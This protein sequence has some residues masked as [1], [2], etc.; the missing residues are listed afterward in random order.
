M[1]NISFQVS[2]TCD[3]FGEFISTIKGI[4]VTNIDPTNIRVGTSWIATGTSETSAISNS[5]SGSTRVDIT[6]QTSYTF[7]NIPDGT[8]FIAISDSN[9]PPNVGVSSGITIA[10]DATPIPTTTPTRTPTSTPTETPISVNCSTSVFDIVLLFDESGSILEQDF[11]KMMQAAASLV[12]KLSP[13][14]GSGF[15]IGLTEF[16]NSSSNILNL[17]SNFTTITNA[18]L[19]NP[20]SF[21]GTNLSLGLDTAYSNVTGI[22]TRN[23]NKKII[24]YTDGNPSNATLAAQSAATI[25][26]SLYN[27][28]YRTEIICV[29]IGSSIDYNFLQN[30]IASSPSLVFSASS[31]NSLSQLNTSIANSI[32]QPLSSPTPT[33]TRTVTQTPTPT[34]TRTA[35]QTPTPTPT[36]TA[37]QTPTPTPTRTPNATTTPTPT[38]NATTTPTATPTKTAP[39]CQLVQVRTNTGT[40]CS[41]TC[42]ILSLESVYARLPLSDGSKIYYAEADPNAALT[43]CQNLGTYWEGAI[44]SIAYDGVC[45]LVDNDGV[46]SNGTPCPTQTQTPTSTQTRTP[47]PTPTETQT[48]CYSFDGKYGA[49]IITNC[50]NLCLTTGYDP[51]YS[52]T[53]IITDGIRIFATFEDCSANNTSFPYPGIVVIDGTCYTVDSGGILSSGTVC[54]TPTPT[55]TPTR[56]ATSTPTRTATSTPTITPTSTPT[57]TATST[58]TRT[59][60]STPTITPTSTP[61]PTPT[62]TATSTPTPTPTRTATSTPTI[63]PTSTPTR[64]ATSTPTR[65]ATSTPT[66]TATSTPTLTPTRTDTSTPTLT[67]TSTPTITA[68]ST[69]TLTPTSTPTI[70]ATS[71]PTL[72]PTPTTSVTATPTLTPTP[73]S[74]P[75]ITATSTPTITAT[76]TP[77][78][79]STPTITATSTPTITATST[80]TST[81]TPTITAT[82]TPTIT[83]TSTPTITPTSTPT[84]TATSTQTPTLTSTNTP[85]ETSTPTPTLTATPT[86]TSTP[87]PTLTSTPTE[88]STPTPTLTATPTETSTPTPT[89]TATPT[90]TATPTQTETSTPTPTLTPTQTETATPTPTPTLTAT[91][92]IV[93]QFQDC[94]DG[95]N[96]FRF[97]PIPLTMAIGEVYFITGSSQFFGCATVV[98][99]NGGGYLFSANNVTFIPIDNCAISPCVDMNFESALFS[100]CSDG[101][102]HFFKVKRDTAFLGATYLYNNECYQFVEFSGPGGDYLEGPDFNSCESCNFNLTKTPTPTPTKPLTPTPTPTITQTAQSC[103]IS[104]YCFRTTLPSLSGYSGNYTQSISYNGRFTY[105]G[106]GLLGGVIYYFT[107]STENY[108]C[109]SSTLGG[110]CLLKGSTPCY[111]ICPD[112]SANLFNQGICPTPTPTPTL[113]LTPTQSPTITPTATNTSTP[114]TTIGSTPTSTLQITPTPT[115]SPTS[116]NILCAGLDFD[117]NITKYDPPTPITPTPTPTVTI[118]K[119][120]EVFGEATYVIFEKYFTCTSVKVLINCDTLEEYYTSDDL[121]FSGSQLTTGTT[122]SLIINGNHICATYDRNDSNVTSNSV[123]NGII[124]TYLDCSSCVI[125]PTPT[126]TPTLT[127]TPTNTITSTQGLSPTPTNTRTNTI[128]PT[129]T[130]TQG[131]VVTPTNTPTLTNTITLTSTDLSTPTNTPTLTEN[132]ISYACGETINGSYSQTG[133]TIQGN[134]ILNL[135]SATNL[136][137]IDLN[138]SASDRPNKFNV[139][140][141][142]FLLISSGWVGGDTSYPGPWSPGIPGPEAGTLSFT[143]DNSKSYYITVDVGPANISNPSTLTDAWSI[144]IVCST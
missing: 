49:D 26:N 39:Q 24:L 140:E 5:Q 59:A 87:T 12:E 103:G 23:T 72:T 111:E 66:I 122:M 22:N 56:T 121:I 81:S 88:T 10:C 99:N 80:P 42:S 106:D 85:T 21:G 95:S 43:A 120:V 45:Y 75:T 124:E 73:T 61:T 63:T 60:T 9:N 133:I 130:S 40:N 58:P 29:G 33:P 68:T 91:K 107:S 51:V 47:T 52:K 78:S 20:Q 37:T 135:T 131:A 30:Y 25:K 27:S 38:P 31:F 4:Y 138:Y 100:K 132:F 90:E 55:P 96:I 19:N 108:W 118:T 125:V 127:N 18:I 94:E 8:Y 126:P 67:P 115:N 116:T 7:L 98:E 64:T 36:R 101:T 2:G 14:L 69:P 112:I 46:L 15:Q 117:L 134:Y 48:F 86:E 3:V 70:T 53:P 35:T 92:G 110:T 71:T 1:A 102:I 62:I 89:L 6:S 142:G 144:T 32:C 34:P 129:N 104:T 84:I 123:I 114:T 74:T 11:T 44:N 97:G 113:S 54:P 50:T 28:L 79:T 77:T 17:N 136:S 65:T 143:Y 141:N 109:L 41:Q 93:T 128:T 105:N 139:Y 57:R 119:T 16:A 76:S 13:Y 82:S 137:T 83:A